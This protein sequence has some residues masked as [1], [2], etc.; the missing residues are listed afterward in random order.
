MGCG[1]CFILKCLRMETN[2][3]CID[4]L[5]GVDID[6]DAMEKVKSQL[7]P[8]HGMKRE[9]PVVVE[10]FKGN[11]VHFEV[12]V[13]IVYWGQQMCTYPCYAKQNLYNS[14]T[15]PSLKSINFIV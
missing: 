5:I 10:L 1:E 15:Q 4:H 11:Q 8:E 7:V 13:F 3:T 14:V 9:H 12:N 2:F 6:V